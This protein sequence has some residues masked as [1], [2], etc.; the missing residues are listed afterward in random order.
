MRCGKGFSWIWAP[1]ERL[2]EALGTLW[3]V[4]RPPLGRSWGLLGPLGALL[5]PSWE[6]SGIL[7]GALGSS[8]GPLGSSWGP[9]GG[10]KRFQEALRG[11]QEVPK[12]P[13]RG[14]QEGLR[15]G[16][17]MS[18]SSRFQCTVAC[19]ILPQLIVFLRECWIA[20]HT[21]SNRSQNIT[22]QIKVA[23]S[24]YSRD[25]SWFLRLRF[26]FPR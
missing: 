8:W 7:L 13:P 21:D 18:I 11:L 25:I 3:D 9:L 5:G 6:L 19:S 2:L 16:S 20:D 15:G 1:F 10:R 22:Q 24:W 23:V 17:K 26:P 12:R 14:P 4:L